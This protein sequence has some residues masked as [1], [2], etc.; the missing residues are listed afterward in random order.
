[1]VTVGELGR[2]IAE[3]AAAD[4]MDS[5]AVRACA[6]AEEA[7]EVL[8]DLLVPGDAVLIKASRCMGLERVVEGIVH[9]R[10]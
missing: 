7:S 8:D 3:G 10:A 6:G 1:L 5:D 2:R 4:G 9:P